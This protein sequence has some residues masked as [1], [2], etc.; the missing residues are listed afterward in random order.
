[1]SE[2]SGLDKVTDT[3]STII[4]GVPAPLKK[5]LL[6]AI[7]QL[8]TAAL[9][10][11]IAWLESKSGEIRAT[12]HARIQI[13]KSEGEKFSE[14]VDI[15]QAYIDKA[16][17]KYAS[18]IIRE[19]I[20]LDDI[21]RKAA[22]ELTNENSTN[23]E[24]ADK[25]ISEDWLSEFETN[26]RQ[27]SSEE[28]KFIFSKILANEVKNPGNF[29]IRTIR[30]ISQLDNTA[31][32]LFRKLCSCAISM[33]DGNH[34]FDT[35]VISL[36]GNAASNSL[37][38]YGFSF[39][40]L[41][42]LQEYGLIISDYNSYMNYIPCV[43]NEQNSVGLTIIFSNEHFAFLPTDRNKYDKNVKLNGV[44]FSKSGQELYTIIPKEENATYKAD[45]ETFL[46]KR[47]LK[48][49]KVTTN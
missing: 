28:M 15:P 26:A 9:D 29:S 4:E 1:M 20:N 43:V 19:Q 46:D 10:I 18:K 22:K 35:R 44:A 7:G 17:E 8:S 23:Q 41:N 12:T 14:Q 33:Q 6:K 16:S 39:D 37:I 2:N 31:A 38:K 32:K 25:E 30:L 48:L 3:V 21:S 40:N 34:I 27:M 13:I 24:N 5:N 11:P 45:L 49:L 36:E 47:Y 42:I